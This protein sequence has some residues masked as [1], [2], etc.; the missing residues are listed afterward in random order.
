MPDHAY[1]AVDGISMRFGGLQVLDDVGFDVNQSEIVGLI[2]PNGA[3]KTTLFDVISGFHTPN[4]GHVWLRD[5][6]ILDERPYRRAWLGMGRPFPTAPL[7]PSQTGFNV[8]RTPC[9][10]R[11]HRGAR[12][13]LVARLRGPPR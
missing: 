10:P 13:R 12:P 8:V 1:F 3:G 11:L 7:F 4:H 5:H 2:G 6:D 9:P